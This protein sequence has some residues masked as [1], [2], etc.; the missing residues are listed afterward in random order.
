MYRYDAALGRYIMVDSVQGEE[1]F[2]L[3]GAGYWLALAEGTE[4]TINP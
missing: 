4:G 3:Q 2:M 1:D